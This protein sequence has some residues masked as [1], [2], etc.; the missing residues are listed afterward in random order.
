VQ[1]EIRIFADAMLETVKRWVPLVH[2]A[3]LQYR[4]GGVH[5]SA[6]AATAIKRMLA[7]EKVDQKDSGLSAREWRETMD[8]LGLEGK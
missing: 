8:A 2:D 3:F 7:G 5:L 6:K 1:Y 4:M